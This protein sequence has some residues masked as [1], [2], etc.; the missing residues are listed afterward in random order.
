MDIINS[1]LKSEPS[2]ESNTKPPST[3]GK[4]ESKA[5]KPSA[6]SSTTQLKALTDKLVSNHKDKAPSKTPSAPTQ[7]PPP[8]PT[9]RTSEKNPVPTHKEGEK[10]IS[11]RPGLPR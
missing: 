9:Q 11:S 1:G 4:N 10:A 6:V 2:S 7:T 8:P 3:E 5:D